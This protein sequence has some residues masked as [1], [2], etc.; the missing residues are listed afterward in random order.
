MTSYYKEIPTLDMR[1]RAARV[2]IVG[3]I[4]GVLQTDT[5]FYEDQTYVRST[6]DV[7]VEEVLKGKIE[8]QHIAVQV[9]GGRTERAETP[10]QLPMREGERMLLMLSEGDKEGIFVPYLGSAFP[11]KGSRVKFGESAAEEPGAP[12]SPAAEPEVSLDDVRRTVAK[13][14]RLRSEEEAPGRLEPAP[15]L[16]MPTGHEGAGQSGAP[17][18]QPG[19]D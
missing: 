17:L 19:A 6:V 5:E 16:E 10:L 4:R 3:T 8:A 15:V 2:V 1:T 12:R 9:L 7:E 11:V 13:V 18:S 14:E